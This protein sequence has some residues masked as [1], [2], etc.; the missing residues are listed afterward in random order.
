MMRQRAW[1]HDEPG[2]LTFEAARARRVCQRC[3]DGGRVCAAYLPQNARWWL[4]VLCP[5]CAE[6]VA[7]DWPDAR[8]LTLLPGVITI[9]GAVGRPWT[10]E[11]S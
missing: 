10:L 2:G 8:V 4:A 3:G 9:T 7:E 1:R 5:V 6:G 11:A